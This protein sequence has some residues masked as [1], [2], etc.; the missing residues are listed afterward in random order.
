MARASVGRLKVEIKDI[1]AVDSDILAVA[2]YVIPSG[3]DAGV[4][5]DTCLEW[6]SYTKE[7]EMCPSRLTEALVHIDGWT[8]QEL[9]REWGIDIPSLP[10]EEEES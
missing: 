8:R 2:E 6:D 5:G 4:W 10:N 9:I 3:E 1:V 7:W